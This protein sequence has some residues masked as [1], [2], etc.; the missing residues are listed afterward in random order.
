MQLGEE[1]ERVVSLKLPR[2]SFEISSI[3][4]DATRQ[5]NKMNAIK[6]ATDNVD[7]MNM[8]RQP[9]PYNLSFEL[10]VYAKS[11]DDALQIV[12]QIIPTFNP[13]YSMTIMPIDQYPEIKEDVPVTLLSVSM[14]DSY[15]GPLDQRRTIIYTLSFTMAVNFYG[16]I[17]DG[18][19]IREV[20][21]KAGIL[22]DRVLSILNTTLD[23]IDVSPDDDYGFSEVWT[24]V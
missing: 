2:M 19:I 12:E 11:Q 16:E 14:E 5:M 6:K 10:S 9:V 4:Y 3:E 20:N 17:G 24:E 23:P 21:A 1:A 13:K 8:V 18:K 7:S 15:E 22:N